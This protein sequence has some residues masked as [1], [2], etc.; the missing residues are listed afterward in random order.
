MAGEAGQPLALTP[1]DGAK[2][3]ALIEQLP[4]GK[5]RASA[6]A[7]LDTLKEVFVETVG[8]E[9]L[10]S[11]QSATDWIHHAART[12]G[13]TAIYLDIKRS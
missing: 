6:V 12:H 1:A 7:K 8:T 9:T 10:D 11:E 3:Q 13:F 5:W 4:D 2:F